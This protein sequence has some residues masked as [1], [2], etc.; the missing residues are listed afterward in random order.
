[1]DRRLTLLLPVRNAQASLSDHV[2]RILDTV[3]DLT[4]QFELVIVDRGSTDATTEV[5]DELARRYPQ[6]R[7][8][9]RSGNQDTSDG[10]PLGATRLSESCIVLDAAD[11]SGSLASLAR[12]WR[13]Q[14]EVL[15]RIAQSADVAERQRRLES[16]RCQPPIGRARKTTDKQRAVDPGRTIGPARPNFLAR[17]KDFA[18]GE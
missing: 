4:N 15:T 6:V 9:L 16:S 14:N 1:M 3:A 11:T 7:A 5:A 10:T 12:N 8:V 2:S 13:N 17:L 18:L